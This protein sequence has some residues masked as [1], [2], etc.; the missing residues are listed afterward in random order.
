MK[1]MSEG[2]GIMSVVCL[3]AIPILLS[4]GSGASAQQGAGQMMGQGG[5][6]SHG[7]MQGGMM[8]PGMMSGQSSGMMPM[9]QGSGCGKMCR[10]GTGLMGT[11][12][13]WGSC[14]FSQKQ[15]LGLSEEQADEIESI[16]SS[17][18]KYATRKNADRKILLME[19]EELLVK[20]K[21]DSRGVKT[22]VKTLEELD[23]DIAMEGIETLEKALAVL[24]P[25][26]QKKI[27]AV[28]KQSCFARTMGMTRGGM[29]GRGAMMGPGMQ[30][31]MGQ[32]CMMGP[33]MMPGMMGQGS[34]MQG[35]GMTGQGDTA[36][37]GK[38][39]SEHKH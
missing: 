34:M 13:Q 35:Q 27:K 25:E 11:L 12:H 8:G 24:T 38:T 37:E 31:M 6:M 26:Q 28:F 10:Q 29:M 4:F 9:M 2:R 30:G 20:E 32:G 21:L 22:K 23:T 36:G 3:I 39:E 33:G 7:M 1:K 5:T 19:I 16:F 18:A 17:H 14:F 15:Q